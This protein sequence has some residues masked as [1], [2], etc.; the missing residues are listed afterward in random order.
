ML[1]RAYRLRGEVYDVIS[2]TLKHT[3]VAINAKLKRYDN[4]KD[5]SQKAYCL[6][7]IGKIFSLTRW[8]NTHNT[9]TI[10]NGKQGDLVMYFGPTC[11]S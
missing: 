3:L 8:V 5:N 6:K 10:G 1:G 2:N 4:R 7:L 11:R 9:D